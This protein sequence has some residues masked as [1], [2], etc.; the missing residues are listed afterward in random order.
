VEGK[1][2]RSAVSADTTTKSSDVGTIDI[3]EDEGDVQS[4]K[5]TTAPSPG[6]Q[7]VEMPR[8]VPGAQG[9]STS[10]TGPADDEGSNKWLKKAPPKPCKPNLRSATK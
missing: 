4:P 8:P 5:A 6:R 2:T 9:R 1:Q 10:S 3:E 7:A